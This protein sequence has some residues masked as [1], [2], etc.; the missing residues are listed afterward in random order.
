MLTH[1]GILGGAS[2]LPL[3]SVHSRMMLEGD[4]LTAGVGAVGPTWAPF[5]S[6]AGAGLF[7]LPIGYNC[8]IGGATALQMSGSTRINAVLAGSPLAVNYLAGVNDLAA[9]SPA[10]A[11][12]IFGYMQTT[13]AAYF[14]AGVKRIIHGTVP[15]PTGAAVMTTSQEA[16]RNALNA[17]IRAQTDKRILVVD[18]ETAYDTT[19]MSTDGMHANYT[20]AQALGATFGAAWKKIIASGDLLSLYISP[21]NKL[22]PLTG[23][24]G[25]LTATGT[26]TVTGTVANNY[27]VVSALDANVVASTTT[28]NGAPA[29]RMVI[30]GSAPESVAS[31]QARMQITGVASGA[32]TGDLIDTWLDIYLA[33]GATG[34][35]D[36]WLESATGATDNGSVTLLMPPA[37][38]AGI[39][40]VP[41]LAVLGSF[42]T[43]DFFLRTRF[44]GTTTPF[45]DV[46]IGRPYSA[47]SPY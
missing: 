39:F 40:R 21:S 36:M 42:T 14:A 5:A 7:V 12:T 35:I 46:T 23:S 3:L 26:G 8:A 27:S 18:L 20:G 1:S 44:D 28:L 29:Q 6:I 25:T 38:I 11:A 22:P 32:S 4:S 45:A 30:T 34:L 43:T 10:S 47:K 31:R 33:P 17:L 19:T 24:G 15:K 16:S 2:S 37:S 41:Q 9:G 13:F